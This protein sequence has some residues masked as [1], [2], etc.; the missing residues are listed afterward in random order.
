MEVRPAGD[1]WQGLYQF[2]VL[3]T[4]SE[5]M[6][7]SLITYADSIIE[8]SPIM[9]HQLSHQTLYA[10][11]YRFKSGNCPLKTAS[12]V[13]ESETDYGKVLPPEQRAKVKG[14]F[15]LSEVEK[16]PKPVLILNYLKE[17]GF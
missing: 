7:D 13:R 2:P 10:R 14:W 1:I 17:A 4:E 8:E 3:E 5:A 16:L 11:F 15:S 6:P 12:V 9:K